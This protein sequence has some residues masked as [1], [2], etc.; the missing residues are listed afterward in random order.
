MPAASSLRGSFRIGNRRVDPATGLVSG[1]EFTCRLRPQ[2]VDLLLLFIDHPGEVLGKQQLLDR[3]WGT[4]FVS[5]SALTTAVGELRE[6]LGDDPRNPTVLQTVPKR[7]YRLIGSV[8]PDEAPEPDLPPPSSEPI[9]IGE[10]APV[11]DAISTTARMSP[12]ASPPSRRMVGLSL[13]AFAIIAMALG[14]M[15]WRARSTSRLT[16]PM[17]L[18]IALQPGERW[19]ARDQGMIAIS[20]DG[21]SLVCAVES[22]NRVRLVRRDLRTRSVTPLEGT[23]G[24]AGPFFSRDG[25]WIGFF[26]GGAFRRI[27]AAGGVVSLIVASANGAFGGSWRSNGDLVFASGPRLGMFWLPAGE[28]TARPLTELDPTNGETSHRYP[29]AL[30]D[31]RFV[32]YTASRVAGSQIRAVDVTT[33][34]NHLVVENSSHARFASPDHI[35]FARGR[36]LM[37]APF[38]P[39]TA[40]VTGDAVEIAGDVMY[41]QASG[42][43]QFAVSAAGVLAFVSNPPR[44]DRELVLV[45]RRGAVTPV[46]AP[47]QPYIH[48]RLSPDGKQIAVWLQSDDTGDVWTYDLTNRQLTRRTDNGVSWRPIW[49]P[50]G[51]QL[52]FDA[53]PSG[54]DNVF[55]LGLAAGSTPV[56]LARRDRV[57]SAEDWFP[58]G[59]SLVL[60]QVEPDTGSDLVIVDVETLRVRPL[61]NDQGSE[62]G[63]AVSPDGRWV[64][65]QWNM[66]SKG[67]IYAVAA[68]GDRTSR[69]QLAARGREPRWGHDG[70]EIFFR[71][72]GAMFAI[73]VSEHA[74]ALVATS[75]IELFRGDFEER[76]AARANYDVLPDGRFLM[77][78]RVDAETPQRIV[79]SLNW[80]ARAGATRGENQK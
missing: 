27:P 43:S 6:A 25:E 33:G 18:P 29:E 56:P 64:A 61:V 63:A 51:R 21:S 40:Q 37:A 50:D 28:A 59:R 41:A 31:S 71:D 45:D 48:P 39:A 62:A 7:G 3:I 4:K 67:G 9:S 44:L 2:I 36:T 26:Q 58:D 34:A 77:L 42:Q 19:P 72:Q 52:A 80:K 66:A 65:F 22:E 17:E 35:L 47:M 16:P 60:A 20:P 11:P 38:D 13:V 57:Q 5:E 53:K 46:G 49:S 76:P 74:G 75:P 10:V 70:R 55:T 68:T 14:G 30:P 69:V 32:L 8:S 12:P 73:G 1:P 79:V 24:A 15:S 23:D 78:R 54:M